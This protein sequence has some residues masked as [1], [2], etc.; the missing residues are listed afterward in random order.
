MTKT[1]SKTIYSKQS[2]DNIL[3][4]L[5]HCLM[6]YRAIPLSVGALKQDYSF[7]LSELKR[8]SEVSHKKLE[9][10]LRDLGTAGFCWICDKTSVNKTCVLMYSVVR[11]LIYKGPVK[12]HS[13]EEIIMEELDKAFKGDCLCVPCIKKILLTGYPSSTLKTMAT[14]RIPFI[15]GSRQHENILLFDEPMSIFFETYSDNI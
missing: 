15:L 11:E 10:N 4:N 12:I 5:G 13:N 7:P 1:S 6:P 3:I 9:N 2:G 8:V 14:N